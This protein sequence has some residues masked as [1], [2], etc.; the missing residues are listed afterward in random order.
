MCVSLN[1]PHDDTVLP[2]D[3]TIRLVNAPYPPTARLAGKSAI[4]TGVGNGIGRGCA[5]MFARH[6]ARVMGC[7]LDATAAEDA[8]AEA[9]GLG[10]SLESLHP[11][12]LTRPGDVDRLI[13][14]TVARL[15]GID[16]LL[17]AAAWGAFVP[18][19]SMDYER[20]WRRTLV[21]ELDIVFLAC[22]AAWP[23]MV[24]RGGGSIINFA[25]AN[26][27]TTLPGSPA[28][29]HCAGKGGVLA[30]TR[31]LAAEGAPH[32]IRANTIS[33][34]LVVTAATRPVIQQPGFLENVMAKSMLKRLGTP[35]DI[36]WCATYL[37]SDESSWVTA[38]DFSIDG[39][40]TR[41]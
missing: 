13:A 10:L 2:P 26:A 11:C 19:E 38:A 7:D 32:G 30:M 22:K 21:C 41:C 34:A 20:D 16:I 17:N 28:L 35:E 1:L 39:G 25:S 40:A 15:G 24:T 33:P 37:A 36:A 12:D 14:Q 18:I 27:H 6:G 9:R 5:L 4:V 3:D 23:H 31:Q 29:A 8:L